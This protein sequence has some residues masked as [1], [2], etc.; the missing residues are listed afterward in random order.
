[1]GVDDQARPPLGGDLA[2]DALAARQP[3]P[4]YAFARAAFDGIEEQLA[5]LRV[6]QQQAGAVGLGQLARLGNRH[7]GEVGQR[8]LRRDGLRKSVDALEAAR[9]DPGEPP[10]RSVD[11]R[12]QL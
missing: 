11:G 1:M 8:E 7:M 12:D 9:L 4:L 2:G 3:H 6:D 5:A 10:L